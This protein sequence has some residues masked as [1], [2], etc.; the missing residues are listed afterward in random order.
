MTTCDDPNKNVLP[1]GAARATASVPITSAAPARFSTTIDNPWVLPRWSAISRA[2]RSLTPAGGVGT[3]ARTVRP[4][5]ACAS[6]SA[7]VTDRR[8]RTAAP[9]R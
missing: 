8:P 2:I 6:Y 7:G 9:A 5:C 1:S 4:D 3:I